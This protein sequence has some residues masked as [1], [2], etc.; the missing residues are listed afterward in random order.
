VITNIV[1][2][3]AFHNSTKILKYMMKKQSLAD[4][5]H[6]A[7]EKADFQNKGG[8]KQEYSGY[9]PL[10]LAVA[11]GGQNLESVKIL[12]QNKADY[13]I[14]DSVGNS[15]LHIAVKNKNNPALEYIL[16]I[17]PE[18]Q[19]VTDLTQRNKQG[20]TPYSIALDAKNE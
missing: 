20:E 11:E 19:L 14:N 1:G 18:Q 16:Q 7:T 17:W 4:I 5:N 6:L 13:T 8:V 12:I 9:T 2:A 15:L 3:A 10:M